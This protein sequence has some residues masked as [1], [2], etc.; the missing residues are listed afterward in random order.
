MLPLHY[1]PGYRLSQI[2]F[3]ATD[4]PEGDAPLNGGDSPP[5]LDCKGIESDPSSLDDKPVVGLRKAH[6]AIQGM[7]CTR[8]TKFLGI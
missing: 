8:Q 1:P 2:D 4:Q 7:T 3:P 5:K 6:F